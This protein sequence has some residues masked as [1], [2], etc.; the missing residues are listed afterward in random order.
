MIE[1]YCQHLL[2]LEYTTHPTLAGWLRG[3]L[4]Q[5]LTLG[6]LIGGDLHRIHLTGDAVS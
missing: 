4:G 6:T 1:L 2:N 3:S 5:E